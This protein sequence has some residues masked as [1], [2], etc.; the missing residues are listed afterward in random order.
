MRIFKKN[1][2]IFL[3]LISWQ[4][5]A[6]DFPFHYFSH[7]APVI[8][9][10]SM[11]AAK[12]TMSITAGAYTVWAGGYKPLND[13][14]LSI[15]F[16]PEFKKYRNYNPN[17]TRVGVG[18]NL[19]NEQIGPFN[20]YLLQL[21][22]AYH[23]PVTKD[24]LLSLGISGIIE[25]LQIDV[26]SLSPGSPDDPRLSG[27]N[28]HAFLIDGGFGAT[29][30][31]DKFMLAFSALN[32]TPGT[33][34]FNEQ[35]AEEIESYRR[36]Y[37]NGRYRFFFARNLSVSPRATLRNSRFRSLN[38]DASLDFGFHYFDVGAGYRS[39]NSLM[40]FFRLP[41]KDF[42]LTYTSENPLQ[43]SHLAGNGHTFTLGWEPGAVFH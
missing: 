17:T 29:V 30:S 18:L 15:A 37:L 14:L 10:P 22:Y 2:L 25:N 11:A 26:N 5:N 19:L 31:S 41:V 32:L 16:S 39:E 20:Q 9:N 36:F 23:I 7:S 43:V 6:Q 12:Q 1:I 42:T 40:V 3:V 34:R 27:G 13:Y 21:M 38:Y 4:V 8:M 33:F 28:N 24:V 35:Q